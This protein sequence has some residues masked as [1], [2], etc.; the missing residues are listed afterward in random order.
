MNID[1]SDID[2]KFIALEEREK[3]IRKEVK[4]IKGNIIRYEDL[5]EKYTEVAYIFQEVA[6]MIQETL[7]YHISEISN[8]AL[9]VIFDDPYEV[10]IEFE[11]K[12]NRSEAQILLKRGDTEEGVVPTDSTGGGVVDVLS[13]G[14]RVSLW[15]LQSDP[16]SPVLIFDE[17]FKFLSDDYKPKMSEVLHQISEKLGLQVIAVTHD[18]DFIDSADKIINVYMKN[19]KSYLKEV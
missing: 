8:M 15:T 4:Q 9:S 3:I 14:L 11:I 7:V 1:L 6:R 19:N 13:F 10:N 17:P 12:R 2:S 5:S 18:T 16:T